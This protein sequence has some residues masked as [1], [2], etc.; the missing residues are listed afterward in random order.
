[1]MKVLIAGGG[2]GGLTTAL[3]LHAVGIEAEVFEQAAEVREVGVGINMLPHAVKELAALGLLPALARVGVCT[4]QLI[5]MNRLG[6]T[7]WQEPRGLDAGYDTP[8]YS[9]HRG[10]LL[11]LL[12]QAVL[13]RLDATQIH[14]DQRLI[15]F[16]E[17][18]DRVVARFERPDGERIEVTGDALIAADG[19]HSTV[20]SILYPDE[21]SPVWSGTML[22]RG[23]TEWP[24]YLDGRTMVIAGGNA[25]KF[26]YYPIHAD[27]AKPGERLTNW[28]VMAR[29]GDGPK[30]LRREDWN[31]PGQLD[32]VLPLVRDKFRLDFTEPTPLI[33]ATETFYEYP[34]CDRD[35]LRRWS[36]G[37]VSLLGDA[38]H[39]MYPTGSNGASQAI[40]DAHSLASHLTART[41][42]VE[43]LAAYDAERRPATAAIVLSNRRGGPE[44]VID[45]VEERAPRGFENIDEVASYAERQSI[46]RSYAALAG[47]AKDQVNARAIKGNGKGRQ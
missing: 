36:F 35:P 38:A 34:N 24:T 1:M 32:E 47:Y 4:R 12:H 21:G 45:M 46:V 33:E 31:R 26:V 40:L 19:I 14:H 44:G 11:G 43:A 7:V 42:I 8:Q 25:A 30:P 6:Q 10:K 5:Y 27:P 37:R 13:E 15:G 20:R 28:A 41:S 29:T 17:R 23:A 3:A 2:I 9:I 16:D 39:P 18:S 22:W